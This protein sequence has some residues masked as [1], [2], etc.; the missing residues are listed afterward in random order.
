MNHRPKIN[1]PTMI[2][3]SINR[4]KVRDI[5]RTMELP[6]ADG[7]EGF[8]SRFSGWSLGKIKKQKFLSLLVFCFMFFSILQSSVMAPIFFS[9]K[10]VEALYDEERARLEAELAAIE[11]EIKQYE[12]L[13][14]TTKAQKQTLKNKIS[15]LKNQAAKI[16]LQIESTNLNLDYLSVM[17]DETVSSIAKTTDKVTTTK[18][19]LSD[20]LQSFYELKQVSLLEILLGSGTISEFFDYS[21]ALYN[22][23][24]RIQENI[25]E[26]EALQ[27][28]L[29]QQNEELEN[30]KDETQTLLAMQLLQ[31]NELKETESEQSHLLSVTEG[32]E[33]KYQQLLSVSQA[34]ANEIRAR[35]YKLIGVQTQVTFGEALEIA[36]WVSNKTGVRTA[37]LLA[38]LTQESNLGQNVG[39]CY[40]TDLATGTGMKVTTGAAV[41]NVMKPMGLSGRKGDVDDFVFITQELGLNPYQT[42]VSCPIPSVGGYGGAMG[43]AQFIPTTWIAYRDQVSRITGNNLAN[44]WDIRDAFVAA[45]LYVAKWGATAQT[46]NAELKAATAYFS[47]STSSKYYSYGESVLAIADRYEADISYLQ[48]I[49]RR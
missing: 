23:Q 35:I 34:K 39:Q 3:K 14:A 16:S 9:S 48:G 31:R 12:G 5:K 22:I 36:T 46:R 49:A 11:Q 45:A 8:L 10:E 26:L 1:N 27:A 24:E 17:I 47:G 44:P 21:N 25:D 7:A 38:I 15:E 18:E 40:L 33:A 13:I 2:I 30:D 4:A 32:N 6:A 29:S 41:K 20:A 37:F 19:N 28:T 43:P 42:A